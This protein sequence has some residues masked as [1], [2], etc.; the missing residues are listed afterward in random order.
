MPLFYK[1]KNNKIL[2]FLCFI[3]LLVFVG[4]TIS[5]NFPN[6]KFQEDYVLFVVKK[7]QN[8]YDVLE[9]LKN[10]HLIMS[11]FSGYLIINFYSLFDKEI[12]P[13]KYKISK[14]MSMLEI[15]HLLYSGEQ[16]I[17]KV[18]INK[19]RQWDEFIKYLQ[20]KLPLD[21]ME[22]TREFMKIHNI[23]NVNDDA[24]LL[25]YIIPD[26]Y[27]SFWTTSPTATAKKFANRYNSFWDSTRLAKAQLLGLSPR[28]VYIIASLVEE[29]TTNHE[30]KPIIASVFIN[31]FKRRMH[32]GSC[33]SVKYALKNFALRRILHKH[34]TTKS[35]YNTY[36]HFGLPPG[37]ICTPSI[38]TMDAVLD[39]P[40]TDYLY[41]VASSEQ[42][43]KHLFS[44]TYKEH[45]KKAKI[46]VN[47]IFVK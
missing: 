7:N 38:I 40:N 15:F 3:V 45:L 34:L 10:E 42:T 22:F 23:S 29:E 33:P 39:A 27:Y 4:I 1:R 9:K 30:E 2:I 21:S 41:F 11:T 12:Y 5:I 25:S 6:T 14:R 43:N 24:V 44:K 35:S 37:P 13:G 28:Q 32:L 20:T 46:Y 16:Y 8:A 47:K 18:V 31:R 19:F 17:I 36:K 26:T